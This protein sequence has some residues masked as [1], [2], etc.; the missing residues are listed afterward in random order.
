VSYADGGQHWR[1]FKKLDWFT[2]FGENAKGVFG[3][4]STSQRRRVFD[5]L[6]E[7]SRARAKGNKAGGVKEGV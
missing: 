3:Q 5:Q 6:T 2:S 7:S 1:V 4:K